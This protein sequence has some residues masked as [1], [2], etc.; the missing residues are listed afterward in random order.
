MKKFLSVLLSLILAITCLSFA[1]CSVPKK[2]GDAVAN[3][4]ENGY[5]AIAISST[6]EIN[7]IIES[8]PGIPA[9][10]VESV[11][12]GVSGT[13]MI[14]I[15]YCSSKSVAKDLEEAL[16][17]ADDSAEFA[18]MEVGRKSKRVWI[19]HEAAIEA[20]K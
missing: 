13:S 10:G 4:T 1:G 8:I 18:G 6:N 5:L 11:V 19:G 2:P 12:T 15:F 14:L 7:E 3:L 20:A 16:D 17:D 9:G